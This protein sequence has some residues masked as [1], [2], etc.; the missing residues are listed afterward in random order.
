MFQRHLGLTLPFSNTIAFSSPKFL[1]LFLYIFYFMSPHRK[2]Y[3]GVILFDLDSQLTLHPRRM[4]CSPKY[5]FIK[6]I[7]RIMASSSIMLQG[8]FVWIP[9]NQLLPH[10]ICYD[11]TLSI[12]SNCL[13]TDVLKEWKSK[14][15]KAYTPHQTISFLGCSGSSQNKFW[16]FIASNA[17]ILFINQAIHPERCFVIGANLSVNIWVCFHPSK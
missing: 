10:I 1:V 13:T 14:I 4:I 12:N 17:K 7:V 6:L 2:L 16:I 3:N 9:I 15:F 8:D 11:V 5:S